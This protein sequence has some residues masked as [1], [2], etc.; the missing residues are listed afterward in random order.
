MT[1]RALKIPWKYNILFVQQRPDVAF[2]LYWHIIYT[3]ILHM[4]W[5]FKKCL[6]IS[7]KSGEEDAIKPPQMQIPETARQSKLL[8]HLSVRAQWEWRP[9]ES[10]SVSCDGK[11]MNQ[12]VLGSSLIKMLALLDHDKLIFSEAKGGATSTV[13]CHLISNTYLLCAITKTILSIYEW[14]VWAN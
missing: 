3:H 4:N 2:T 13:M 12:G 11:K 9:H 5:W 6:N 7:L 8:I 1:K 10:N 14:R